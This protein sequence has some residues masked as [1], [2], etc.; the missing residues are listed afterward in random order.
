MALNSNPMQV[1]NEQEEK[2][3]KESDKRE[4]ESGGVEEMDGPRSTDGGGENGKWGGSG[5]GGIGKWREKEKQR[6]EKKSLNKK[7]EGWKWDM[8]S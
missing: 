5:R 3:G 8:G 6:A 1:G 7:K 2:G 4:R